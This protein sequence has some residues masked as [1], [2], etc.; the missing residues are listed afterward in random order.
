MIPP[1]SSVVCKAFPFC[2]SYLISF[3]VISLFP[4]IQQERYQA[5]FNHGAASFFT[6]T[7]ESELHRIRVSALTHKTGKVNQFYG[8]LSLIQVAVVPHWFLSESVASD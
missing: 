7:L 4:G 1:M 6:V 3:P 5:A 2:I 8:E